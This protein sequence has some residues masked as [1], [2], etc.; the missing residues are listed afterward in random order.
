MNDIRALSVRQPW[1]SLILS[2]HKTVENRTWTTK[3]RGQIV[4]HAGQATVRLGMEM[5]AQHGIDVLLERGYVGTVELVDIHPA[6]D[7]CT[8]WGFPE[9]YHWELAEP[10]WIAVPIPGPGR[11]GL[12]RPPS[13]ILGSLGVAA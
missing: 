5:A 11:L 12:Y 9:S 8:P 10:R 6:E 2:G 13:T 3:Y 4:I 7:C 1:A